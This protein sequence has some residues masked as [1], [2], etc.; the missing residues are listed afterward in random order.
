M[1]EFKTI[2][3]KLMGH[4]SISVDAG[5]IDFMERNTFYYARW[6]DPC[7]A[8]LFN[9]F[10]RKAYFGK[11]TEKI[12]PECIQVWQYFDGRWAAAI[13]EGKP[14]FGSLLEVEQAIVGWVDSCKHLIRAGERLAALKVRVSKLQNVIDLEGQE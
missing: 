7:G 4:F 12:K 1:D 8:P 11:S 9:P 13:G 14:Y 5:F 6:I 3:L 10:E 2:A